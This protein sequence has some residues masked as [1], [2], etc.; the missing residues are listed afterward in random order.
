MS[1]YLELTGEEK[2][3]V[4]KSQL[5]NIQ[6]N[7]YSLELNILQENSVPN[8]SEIVLESYANEMSLYSL[9]ESVLQDKLD[10]LNIQYPEVEEAI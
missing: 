10:E 7:K 5:K 4:V 2:K 8:P 9:K 1:E 6:L 3:Q